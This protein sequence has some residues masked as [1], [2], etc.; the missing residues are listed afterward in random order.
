MLEPWHYIALLG[1]VVAVGALS[2]PKN[3]TSSPPAQSVQ[4]METALEQFMENMEK[5]NDELLQM[6]AKSQ[7]DA[8]QEDERKDGRIEALEK[9]CEALD[10]RLRETLDKLAQHADTSMKTAAP[11]AYEQDRRPASADANGD[12]RLAGAS[13]SD[14]I[15]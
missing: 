6:I 13:A 15:P 10:H 12:T 8:K 14:E 9:R 1:A 5:D 2:M 11:V 3:R 4:N 7:A